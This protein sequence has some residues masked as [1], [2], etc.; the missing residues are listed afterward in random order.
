MIKKLILFF[1]L[2]SSTYTI[3]KSIGIVASGGVSL[4]SYEAGLLYK[5]VESQKNYLPHDLKVVLGAS[6]G[7]VNGLITIFE[8]CRLVKSVENTPLHWKMWIPVGLDQLESRN[9]SNTSLFHRGASNALFYEFRDIWQ[10]GLSENCNV[11]FGVTVTRFRPIIDELKPG[12]SLTRQPEVFFVRIRGQGKLKFPKVENYFIDG[13]Q[14]Y[15]TALPFTNND[16]FNLELLLDLV[17]ASAAFPLAF[18][19][20]EIEHCLF[21]PGEKNTTCSV[22]NSRKDLFVDGG[23]YQNSP[24]GLGFK[25]LKKE[26]PA[27]SV[28]ELYYIN[29]SAPYKKPNQTNASDPAEGRED[30]GIFSDIYELTLSFLKTSRTMTLSENIQR[31]PEISNYTKTNLKNYPLFSEPLFAFLGFIETDFR[32]ADFFLGIR[33]AEDLFQ[34]DLLMDSMPEY[35]CF[36]SHLEKINLNCQLSDNLKILSSY[37]HS[38]NETVGLP[39]TLESLFPYLEENSFEFKDLK[40][41][42]KD[43]V[44]GRVALKNRFKKLSQTFIQKQP[45]KVQ[46]IGQLLF[47][48]SLN[49]IAFQP[50]SNYTYFL[51]G[52]SP[53]LGFSRAFHGKYEVPTSLRFNVALLFRGLDNYFNSQRDVWAMVPLVGLRFQPYSLSRSLWQMNF[54][55]RAGYSISSRSNFATNEC[56]SRNSFYPEDCS[57][58]IL[59]Q[60]T[61][62]TFLE[63]LRFQLVYT[64][65]YPGHRIEF[66]NSDFSIQAGIV[67]PELF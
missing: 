5:F 3:A 61:S 64:P 63:R 11:I 8:S 6:A 32:R 17:Q 2:N 57:G 22:Q 50:S 14:T 21:R 60:V 58:W 15:R 26:T 19:P 12:L 54:G 9:S 4:G 62:I 31:N 29:A 45:K 46:P 33:D 13:N 52:S 34:N 55:L 65:D 7:G 49:Q 36:K 41:S 27:Q 47:N 53:E 20:Y 39:N 25:I 48:A 30:L 43:S 66:K 23:I 37:V 18:P 1:V 42:K 10:Q 40:L 35:N 24:V 59:Q 56:H 38:K 16:Q 28:P 51:I 44:Y 67:F